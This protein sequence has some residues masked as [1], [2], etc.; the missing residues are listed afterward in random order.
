[1]RPRPGSSAAQRHAERT[2]STSFEDQRGPPDTP[3][4]PSSTRP[5]SAGTDATPP[6][7][8]DLDAAR[9]RYRQ[10]VAADDTDGRVVWAGT[11]VARIHE[12]LPAGD[13]VRA[14]AGAGVE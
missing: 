8:A 10:A 6:C 1:M 5:S 2:C 13:I 7:R 9:H 3:G 12:L 4:A 14:I 11:G